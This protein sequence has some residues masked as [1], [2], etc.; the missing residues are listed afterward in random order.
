[1]LTLVETSGPLGGGGS[2]AGAAA[3]AAG[4][5]MICVCWTGA[6]GAGCGQQCLWQPPLTWVRRSKVIDSRAGTVGLV[7]FCMTIACAA[8]V[9]RSF[10][11][12]VAGLPARRVLG[13]VT[14]RMQAG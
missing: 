11:C 6:A 13:F 12:D 3:G 9:P 7:V 4:S 8:D 5:W 2:G 10:G 14:H 1:M